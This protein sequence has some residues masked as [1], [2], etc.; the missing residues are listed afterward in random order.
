MVVEE[1]IIDRSLMPLIYDYRKQLLE[2]KRIKIIYVYRKVKG[3]ADLLANAA[4]WIEEQIMTLFFFF[5]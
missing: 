1:L 5:P 4:F 3:V 2:F